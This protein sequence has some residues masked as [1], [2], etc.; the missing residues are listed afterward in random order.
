MARKIFIAASGQNIGKTTISVS[1]LHL[2]QKKYGRVG[3][4]KPLGPKPTVLRGIPVDKDA[5]LMAQVFDLTKDLRYMSPVVV[6]PETSR[7]AIDGELNLPELADCIMTSF[8]ELEK[9]CDFIV[10][11]GS[12]HPGVGSVLNLSNARIAKMLDAPV[13]MLSG[14]GVG[15]VIDTLAMNTALFKLEEADVRGVLVNKLF[16]DKRETVLDYLGR[17]FIDQPF[18]VLGGFDYKP[19]LANPSLVR[20]ARLLDLPLHGNR[21]EVKRI[22]HHVQI[23][24]ASTQRVTE[25][26]RDSS[27]LLVTS[28]RDELLVTL[29][30]LYQMPEFHQQIAGLVISGQAP[31]SGIT[32]RIIDR[33]NIPYF[34]TNQTTTDLYKLITEDVSKLTAK[35]TEKLNLIRSLAEERLDFDAIDALFAQ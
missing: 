11:E 27:L 30:N 21:R 25:M 34:R 16:T 1:L 23:G 18:S 24:A 9:H 35:D 20:V 19:V 17:A 3:F 22:I 13:L 26:L 29:A 28:S 7:Q 14:G 8:A 15:N 10:I 2:A 4:M 32:Q 31:V 5:A 6:Y 33:S 12:G